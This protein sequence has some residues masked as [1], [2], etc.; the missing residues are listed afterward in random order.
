VIRKF[1]DRATSFARRPELSEDEKA[2]LIERKDWLKPIVRTSRSIAT[3]Y[4]LRLMVDQF[5]T[6]LQDGLV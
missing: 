5:V 3:D 4:S 2:E 1:T 6:H